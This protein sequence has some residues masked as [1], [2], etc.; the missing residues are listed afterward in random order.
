M[1]D[2]IKL[3]P[4]FGKDEIANKRIACLFN[5]DVKEFIVKLEAYNGS[6]IDKR[7]WDSKFWRCLKDEFK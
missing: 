4:E 3:P 2:D 6:Y 7:F 1:A 5:R